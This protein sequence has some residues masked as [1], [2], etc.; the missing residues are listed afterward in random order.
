M[1]DEI[2][3]LLE[4]RPFPFRALAAR[5]G[6]SGA[7]S[8]ELLLAALMVARLLDGAVP[9]NALPLHARQARSAAARTWLA[10]LALPAG[11]RAVLARAIDATGTDDSAALREAA[12]AVLQLLTPTLDLPART[13]L[14]RVIGRI[15][16]VT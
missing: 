7:G 10:T 3:T 15:P 8:C 5:A 9:P 11:T 6:A 12:G 4:L 1:S 14:Q 2:T 13:E 16:T